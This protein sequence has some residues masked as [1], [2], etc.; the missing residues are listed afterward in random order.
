MDFKFASSREAEPRTKKGLPQ[1]A[2]GIY[3]AGNDLVRFVDPAGLLDVHYSPE[4]PGPSSYSLLTRLAGSMISPRVKAGRYS[5]NR[6]VCYAN[7]P[8][9]PYSRCF[10]QQMRSFVYLT[11]RSN[12]TLP[13]G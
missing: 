9:F 3:S 12:P 13:G 8:V 11:R 10:S 6:V 4:R 2:Q 1:K 5:Q 7:S